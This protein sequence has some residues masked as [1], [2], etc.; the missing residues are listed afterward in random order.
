MIDPTSEAGKLLAELGQYELA[1]G[2]VLSVLE[3]E[4]I[5][6]DALTQAAARLADFGPLMARLEAGE[7]PDG[8]EFEAKLQTV[9]LQHGILSQAAVQQQG[10]VG[11]G[12]TK[13]REVRRKAGF[14]HSSGADVGASCDIA[15]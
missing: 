5:G 9:R 7:L 6:D 1:L 10:E 15:G 4:G 14:Y 11:E 12:L 2:V 3:A 8:P 13:V